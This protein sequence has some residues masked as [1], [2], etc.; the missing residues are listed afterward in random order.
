MGGDVAS[1]VQEA[2][3]DAVI[4][5]EMWLV[6]PPDSEQYDPR[7]MVI[8]LLTTAYPGPLPGVHS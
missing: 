7:C 5:S 4:R 3:M 6:D 2:R 8:V 1:A